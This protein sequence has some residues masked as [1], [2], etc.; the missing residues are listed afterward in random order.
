M[1]KALA[2][3]LIAYLW[4]TPT[5]SYPGKYAQI[6]NLQ[7]LGDNKSPFQDLVQYFFHQ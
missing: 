3:T 6:L 4:E 1:T 2:N 5:Q 7:E